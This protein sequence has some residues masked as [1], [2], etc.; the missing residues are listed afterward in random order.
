MRYTE[1]I[2]VTAAPIER[3]SLH[4]LVAN[5][6]RDMIIEGQL[7]PG[8]SV[9][10]SRLCVELGVSRTPMREAIR[11]LAS[12]GL[13]VLRPGRSTVVRKFSPAEVQ[14]MLEVVAELEALAARQAC[15]RA[16][17]ATIA[18]IRRVHDRMLDHF[19][20]GER[21]PY[22]KLNQQIHTMIV[23]AAGNAALGEVHGTLQARMKRIRF[24]GGDAPENWRGAVEEHDEMV[25]ALECRDADR[26]ADIL[27][28]H[29]RK[30]W[31]RVV[32]SI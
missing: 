15:A 4:E 12:E 32:G 9:N 26:L 28:L 27:R 31:D 25:A 3:Q 19:R 11:T 21:L 18:A 10:E 6:L 14:G 20:A 30:T 1:S 7:A 16:D 23:A 8:D 5:R 2:E 13:I 17:E 22:Y 24:V 29:L